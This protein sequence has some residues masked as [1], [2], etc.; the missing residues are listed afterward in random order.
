MKKITVM[1]NLLRANDV[2]AMQNKEQCKN[3]GCFSINMLG[4]PGSGKTTLL[5][6]TIENISP[7][8]NCAVIE[9]D[10]Y[11]DLDARRLEHTGIQ[12]VQLNTQGGCHLDAGM[13]Q[14]ALPKLDIGKT[15][16]LFIENV[17]N[18]VCP[19]SFDLGEDI[20][21]VVLSITEGDDKPAKYMPMFNFVHAVIINKIDLMDY[22]DFDIKRATD[23]AQKINPKLEVIEVSAKTGAGVEHWVEYIKRHLN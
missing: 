13:V 2:I 1:S 18:L 20:R 7:T 22:C 3:A 16:L 5:Q 19:A 10:L 12:V 4:S 11:T 6:R 23:D 8:V 9:G 14:A 21:V 17:G 15:D